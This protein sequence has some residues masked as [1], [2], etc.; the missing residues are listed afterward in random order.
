MISRLFFGLAAVL[1]A[2]ALAACGGDKDSDSSRSNPPAGV[3]EQVNVG[4]SVATLQQLKSFRFELKL[5]V[6]FSGDMTEDALG[7]ALLGAL[8]NIEM[9]G[10]YVAPDSFEA[11]VQ[12]FGEDVG[13]VQIGDTAWVKIGRSWEATNAEDLGLTSDFGDLLGDVL[14]AEVLDVA[15]TSREKVNGVETVKYSWDKAALA[16]LLASFGETADMSDIDDASLSIWMMD[17]V[18][19]VKMSMT[20]AG[21]DEDGNKMSMKLDFNLRDINDPGIR[22]KP[23][24]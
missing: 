20:L 2:G 17:D 18:V 7:A 15:K 21:S 3:L 12:M 8:G 10:A 5:S 4:E 16:R 13:F 14:P 23:P 6:D 11:Q 9:K 24:V 22:I 19:P 1:A